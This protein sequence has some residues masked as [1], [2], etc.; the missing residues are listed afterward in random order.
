[1]TRVLVA[2]GAPTRVVLAVCLLVIAAV[3][4]L[5]LRG[6]GD[7]QGHQRREQR[8]RRQGRAAAAGHGHAAADSAVVTEI[9]L[10]G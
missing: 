10:G 7:V 6:R 9:G 1:M 2:L 8:A 3:V 4:G 5:T